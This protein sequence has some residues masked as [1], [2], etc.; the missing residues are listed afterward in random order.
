MG[1]SNAHASKP[2]IFYLK[3]DGIFPNSRLPVIHYRDVLKLPSLTPG[4]Y[5]KNL[6]AEND[7]RNA[8]KNGIYDYHHYHSVTHEVLGAY[9]GETVV[10]LGGDHG[11]ELI[12][13]KGD[14]LIIPAGVAH[15]NLTPGNNF[16][17]VGAYPGGSDYD[18]NYG[19]KSERPRADKQI[20]SVPLPLKDPVFGT[21]GALL[22]LWGNK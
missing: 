9:K 14:V 10:Q 5:V 8:W 6:F 4:N 1:M 17:C 7:W 2:E 16:K 11:E 19:R 22:H 15:K 3:D 21:Y 12:F 13:Q 20:L 18:M